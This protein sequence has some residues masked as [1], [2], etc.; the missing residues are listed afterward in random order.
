MKILI[1]CRSDRSEFYKR[2]AGL[3]RE[4]APGTVTVMKE[5]ALEDQSLADTSDSA[6]FVLVVSDHFPPSSRL[7]RSLR[8]ISREREAAWSHVVFA[9]DESHFPS[10]FWEIEFTDYLRHEWGYLWHEFRPPVTLTFLWASDATQAC[11]DILQLAGFRL[12]GGDVTP[13]MAAHMNLSRDVAYNESN[14]AFMSTDMAK[15]LWVRSLV[16]QEGGG[17]APRTGFTA[18]HPHECV[19]NAWATL[20]A[21]AHI[22]DAEAFAQ[23]REHATRELT[24]H[25]HTATVERPLD[26]AR[27]TAIEVVPHVPGLVFNPVRASYRWE[28][29]WHASR[30]RFRTGEGNCVGSF[31]QGC[32][33]FYVGPVLVA[34]VPISLPVFDKPSAERQEKPVAVHAQPF[35]RVFVSYAHQDSVVVEALEQAYKALGMPYLRDVQELRSGDN[36]RQEIL[37][38]IDSAEVFQLCWSRSA[39]KSVEVRK[40][41]EYAWNRQEKPLIRPC[42]WHQKMPT[43]WSELKDIHFASLDISRFRQAAK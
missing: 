6:L 40:E 28:E 35:A 43:P 14:L 1:V 21:Y 8:R 29:Q 9:L 26:I 39:K 18:F 3:L 12:T 20:L 32:I 11:R 34:E 16:N 19:R 4:Y 7:Y 24:E 30:F 31:A 5:D 36:W 25:T 41:F 13:A 42:R 37:G 38:L 27:G 2:L 17:A 22:A 10:P 33:A 15:Q 23:V